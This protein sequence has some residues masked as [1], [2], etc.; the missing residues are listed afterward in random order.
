MDLL[1]GGG[2]RLAGRQAL[3]RRGL[4]DPAFSNDPRPARRHNRLD[5]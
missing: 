2:R 3:A 5:T 1:S 4:R